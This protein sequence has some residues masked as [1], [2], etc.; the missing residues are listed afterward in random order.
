MKQK[1]ILITGATSGIGR[2][3]AKLLVSQGHKVFASGRREELLE[4]LAQEVDSR[5]L[6]IFPL[7]VTSDESIELMK[8]KVE[9][10]TDQYGLDVLINNAGFGLS[11]A[12]ETISRDQW[13]HQF[14]VNLYGMAMCTNAFVPRMRERGHGTIINTSSVVGKVALPYQGVYC[15]SKHAVEGYSDALRQ[16]LRQFGVHVTM[17]EPGPI[18]TEFEEHA[19]DALDYEEQGVYAE[20]VKRYFSYVD[21]MF[22]KAPPASTVAKT[23]AKA[24]NARKPKFRYVT[25]P[26]QNLPNVWMKKFF[27]ASWFDAALRRVMNL[28]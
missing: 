4:S 18:S 14:N 19:V 12:L 28:K 21:N 3:T 11:G 15:A 13:H 8:M 26:A 2:E 7:D 9:A 24:V 1:S 17:I 23:M 10:E 25:P 22:K 5:N 20:G 16:E 6:V 27:P